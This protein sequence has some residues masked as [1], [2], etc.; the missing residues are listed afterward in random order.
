MAN[1]WIE[2]VQAYAKKHGMKYN[3]AMKD[4]KCKEAYKKGSDKGEK[5]KM[6]KM[7]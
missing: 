6:M 3:E 1:K 7:K 4:P 5:K 2:H